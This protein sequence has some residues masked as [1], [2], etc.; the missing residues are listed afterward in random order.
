MGETPDYDDIERAAERISDHVIRTPLLWSPVLSEQ[1]EARVFFKP[2]NLQRTGTFKFRGGYN[3][4]SALGPAA[5]GGIVTC[6]SGNHAQGVAEAARLAGVSATI[7]MPADAPEVKKAG[8]IRAGGRIVDYD[9]M[10]EDR[11]TVAEAVLAEKGGN[12]IHP[13]N[14]AD[15]IAGQGTVG[16]EI[17]ED[18][19]RIGVVPDHVLV[20]CGGGGL[21][22]GIALA[23]HAR[24]PDATVHPVEPAG[25]DDYARS[26]QSGRRESNRALGGSVCD[27]LLA[28]SPGVM[29]FEINRRHCGPG[30]VVDD[31]DAL[32]AVGFACR[33]LKL[34]VEPGGAAALAALRTGRLPAK[35]RTIVVVLSGGNIEDATLARALSS[36]SAAQD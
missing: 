30:L 18:C 27:A 21:T 32:Q 22:A 4:V 33:M 36:Y 20:P 2:E 26:L 24:I 9:R 17:A 14:N 10:N 35:G 6:S 12:M 23:M 15:V 28:V 34:V 31:E 7:V 29:G 8:V 1:L 16:L 11:D 13:Y 3:A 19:E 25:F 5:A